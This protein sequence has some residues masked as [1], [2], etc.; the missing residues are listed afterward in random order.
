[1]ESI[2]AFFV[3]MKHLKC[4]QTLY[5]LTFIEESGGFAASFLVCAQE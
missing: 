4:K 2:P 5:L 1:M 3:F